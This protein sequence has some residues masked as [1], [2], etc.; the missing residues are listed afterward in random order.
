MKRIVVG[1]LSTLAIIPFGNNAFSACPQ[2]NA[3]FTTSQ[4]TIC[5]PG[6]QVIS[7]VNTSTGPNNVTASYEWFLNGVSFD[8]TV[9]LAAPTTSTI[10]AVGTYTYKLIVTDTGP[11][12]TDTATVVVQVYPVPNA[13]FN[14]NPNNQCAGLPVTFTNTSTGTIGGTT[15]AWNF[16]DGGTATTTNATHTFAAGGTYNVSL[17]QTNGPGCTNTEI[18]AV[19]ALDIPIIAISGADGDGDL[20]NCLLPADPSTSEVVTF[21][22]TTVNGVSYTWDFGDGTPPVTTASLADLTHT[23]TAHGTYTVTMTATHANGCT[24]T[25]TLTVVFEKYVSAAM[26]LDITEYSG[27]AP[28]DLSTLTNLSVNANQYTWNFGDGTI[29]TTTSPIPPVHNYTVAGTYTI[30]LTAIN[31]CN[32]ANST[33]SP[34]IIVAGPTANFNNSLAGNPGCAPQNVTYANTSTG[35]SP[36]NNYQWNMGNGNSYVNVI[37]PPMQTYTNVGTYTVTL[38]AGNA[39]GYD[40]VT[41]TLVIDTIPVVDITS[42]PTNGCSPLT[43]ATTNN[44]YG[45]PINYTWT[46]DGIF[47][48]NMVNLPNQTFINTG[49]NNPVNHTIQLTGSNHCGSDT[50]AETITVHPVTIANFT[51]NTDTICAGSNI[52]FTSTSTGEALTYNWDFGVSTAATAG[53]HT[54]NYPVAGTYAVSLTVTGFCGPATATMNVVVL[55]IPVVN[56]TAAPLSVCEG[57]MISFTNTSTLGGTYNWSFGGGTPATSNVYAPAPVTFNTPGTQTITLNVNILGCVNSFTAFVTINPLPAPTFTL[58]TNNGCTPLPVNF[59]YT[60]VALPGDTYDWNFGNGNTST[61]VN[62]PTETYVALANDST[63]TVELVVTTAAGCS[64]SLSLNI[65]VHPLPIANYTTL[66]DTACA[67]TPIGFLN[68]S[69]GATTY[70]WTF[71]DGAVSAVVSPSHSYTLTGDITTQLIA[72]TAFGCK[73]TLQSDIYIDSIPTASFIFDIVCEIDT[74]HFTDLSTGSVTNWSWNFG[75]ASPLNTDPSPKS[76]CHDEVI[77][78][79]KSVNEDTDPRQVLPVVKFATGTVLTCTSWVCVLVQLAGLVT[80]RLTL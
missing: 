40:T 17:T 25:A 4:T 74:T 50:D 46:V 27:C 14:F 53:P 43:V 13:N 18:Q 36:A 16:G 22:N 71:G 61:L 37:T 20:I 66:P 29:V 10:S 60:G 41:T 78:V 15:Y 57:S 42:I 77:P 34:I 44:S 52:T 32:T 3:A 64:D 80:V 5:G 38:I 70:A 73:D 56:F 54:I 24:A 9:G 62:P 21:S 49:T 59:N 31:S 23:Y 2:V 35:T 12:C 67:G 30:S 55:P 58:S 63:Y 65:V 1:L 48:G 26:T 33:I 8:N 6:P 79:D 28:H 76:H 7:F 19:T 11:A 68:N 47:A 75:D 72:T 69:I 51:A 39:C 45:A